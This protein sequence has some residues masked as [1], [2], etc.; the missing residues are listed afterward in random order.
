LDVQRL[1]AFLALIDAGTVRNIIPPVLSTV[2]SLAVLAFFPTLISRA[3]G[4]DSL[5]AAATVGL[6]VL[7]LACAIVQT[8]GY[9]RTGAGLTQ[10]IRR[11]VFESTIR[12][13]LPTT[14]EQDARR[15]VTVL[16]NEAALFG[17][18]AGVTLGA[19][20]SQLLLITG[21]VIL[22]AMHSLPLAL[23]TVGVLVLAFGGATLGRHRYRR[24][25]NRF[26]ETQRQ[27]ITMAASL[28][29]RIQVIKA[30]QI[31]GLA[32]QRY[33]T[34][35]DDVRQASIG[36]SI[37]RATM[38]FAALVPII[39]ALAFIVM[40]FQRGVQENGSATIYA[41][42]AL[43]GA[44][45]LAS[46]AYS[47]LEGIFSGSRVQDWLAQ[48]RE[49][50]PPGSIDPSTGGAHIAFQDVSFTYPSTGAGIERV[51]AEAHPGSVLLIDGPSGSGK[52][53]LASLLLGLL[54]PESGR[55]LVDGQVVGDGQLGHLRSLIAWV[56]QEPMLMDGTIR[57]NLRMGESRTDAELW[58][59]LDLASLRH[60]VEGLPDMLE[61]A[62]G[63]GGERMSQ[64][65]RQRMA[66]A[67]AIVRRCPVLLLDEPT[68]ALDGESASNVAETIAGMRD[69][70]K[71]IILISHDPRFLEMADQHISIVN[72]RVLERTPKRPAL[73]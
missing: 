46:T 55:L 39:G 50:A 20:I 60:W 51:T 65:Q 9:A 14:V 3:A 8:V 32:I 67:R 58:E 69:A 71:T 15:I 25:L 38:A 59:A 28:V 22:T 70:G 61:S 37:G 47:L 24:A 72:G 4:G 45:S 16:F 63:E 13:P 29:S 5:A 10:L 1:R 54:R 27:A 52:S 62:I 35:E 17:N 48:P 34:T 53:T 23:I 6:A 56:P 7:I 49:N 26:A 43:L 42:M 33:V 12:T 66:L 73:L 57:E 2:V 11:R 30:Y 18:L 31:E 44:L 21:L 36:R 64:G 19:L 68:S 40:P 41:V